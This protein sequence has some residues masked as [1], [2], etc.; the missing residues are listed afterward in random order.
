MLGLD[1]APMVPLIAS[2][3]RPF[4]MLDDVLRKPWSTQLVRYQDLDDIRT[5]LDE[6][7][8]EIAEAK[9]QE[10]RG[11]SLSTG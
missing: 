5:N 7:L 3:Q 1:C 6:M 4:S 8:I 11:A 9:V 10:L 2:G